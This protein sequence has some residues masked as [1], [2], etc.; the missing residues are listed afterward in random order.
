MIS[1]CFFF[2]FSCF[3]GFILLCAV[4]LDFPYGSGFAWGFYSFICCS[5]WLLEKKKSDKGGICRFYPICI[6]N[7]FFDLEISFVR[8][9]II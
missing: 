5:V 1:C 4:L 7:L 8:I 2:S 3:F 6:A 9:Y